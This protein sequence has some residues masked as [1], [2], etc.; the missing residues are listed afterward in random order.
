V[1]R[2]PSIVGE[3]NHW[4][5]PALAMKAYFCLST[6][7]LELLERSKTDDSVDERDASQISSSSLRRNCRPKMPGGGAKYL[8]IPR[9]VTGSCVCACSCGFSPGEK[10]EEE[11]EAA[12]LCAP[13]G[14]S[15][16]QAADFLLPFRPSWRNP[17][18]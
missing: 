9:E 18:C 12:A 11:E 8:D 7:L 5:R 2:A 3:A 13:M 4:Q 17:P 14:T 10:A 1:A 15:A 16:R 6:Q